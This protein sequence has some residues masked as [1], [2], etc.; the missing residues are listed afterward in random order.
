MFYLY[1]INSKQ[2]QKRLMFIPLDL[3][4]TKTQNMY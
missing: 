4:R 1:M 3:I 2:I